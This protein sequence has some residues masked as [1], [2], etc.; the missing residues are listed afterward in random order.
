MLTQLNNPDTGLNQE[1]ILGK[2]ERLAIK[3]N[4]KPPFCWICSLEVHFPEPV[5]NALGILE[6][7][8]KKWSE[9]PSGNIGCG[10]G[11]LI[12]PRHILTAS[13]VVTGVKI[14]ENQ[15]GKKVLQTVHAIGV[16]VIPGRNDSS[17]DSSPFGI[18][19][20]N[21]ISIHPA[22]L[23][24]LSG[25]IDSITKE[26]ILSALPYDIAILELQPKI[27][28]ASG[29]RYYLGDK[30][31]WWGKS[32]AYRFSAFTQQLCG[33]LTQKRVQIGGFPGEKGRKSCS[34][35]Y[36][37]KGNILT[38]SP[39]LK[40]KKLD[41]LLY[42]ADTSAGMSGSPVWFKK[43]NGSFQLIGVHTSFCRFKTRSSVNLEQGN[44]GVLLT[45]KIA[46][47]INH[48]NKRK[49]IPS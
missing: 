6:Q 38:A 27:D 43:A 21:R 42:D 40:G 34:L 22:F 16:K 47:W 1:I 32:T 9:I 26:T 39:S 5:M 33:H 8:E 48:F 7:N 15:S 28:R 3:N 18:W 49:N 13:H 37:S 46:D 10:S 31:A 25:S 19:K 30:I 17:T 44:L 4:A 36:L 41:L 35:P 12:S 20:T 23:Q 29:H 45:N 14:S 11:L 24:R 2:D